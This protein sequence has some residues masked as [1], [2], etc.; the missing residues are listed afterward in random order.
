MRPFHE[1][2]AAAELYAPPDVWAQMKPLTRAAQL[3]A[4]ATSGAGDAA[5][6][7]AIRD[8]LQSLGAHEADGW[9]RLRAAYLS[10]ARV[11]LDRRA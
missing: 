7:Q 3:R 9:E 8:E 1:A 5:F 6:H 2:L 11:D 10:A 4:N